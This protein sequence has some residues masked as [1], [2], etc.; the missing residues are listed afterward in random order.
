MQSVK[1]PPVSMK[2]RQVM[3]GEEGKWSKREEG[4]LGK[5]RIPNRE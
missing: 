5:Y 1:V 3:E 4:K 2:M